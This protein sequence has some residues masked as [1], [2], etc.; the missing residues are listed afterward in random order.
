MS[1]ARRQIV[2]GG[3]LRALGPGFLL[4]SLMHL[5]ALLVALPFIGDCGQGDALDP[6]AA[7]E[8]PGD[9]Q[10]DEEP[11]GVLVEDTPEARSSPEISDLQAPE[12]PPTAVDDPEPTLTLKTPEETPPEPEPRRMLKEENNLIVDQPLVKE[13]SEPPPDTRVLGPQDR[14]VLEE[15]QPKQRALE[16]TPQA[17]EDPEEKLIEQAEED[18]DE[19]P[20]ETQAG[21]QDPKGNPTQAEKPAEPASKIKTEAKAESAQDPSEARERQKAGDPGQPAEASL[22]EEGVNLD[23][24]ARDAA[25]A[26]GAP[27]DQRQDQ[28]PDDGQEPGQAGDSARFDVAAALRVDPGAYRQMFG[29][30]D[31]EDLQRI[32]AAERRFLGN[33]EKRVKATRAALENFVPHVRYGN[34]IAINTRHSEY[35]VYIAAVHRK[36]HRLWG[37][38]YL[39]HLDLHYPMG[40]P[41]SDP[42]LI[43]T[44]EY[45]IDARTGEL[46]ECTIVESS[47][48][49]EFDAEAIRV[50]FIT[51]PYGPAPKAITSPDGNVYL[52]W[53]YHR[54][55]RQCGTF[56]VSVYVLDDDGRVDRFRVEE[57]LDDLDHRHPKGARHGGDRPKAI[58]PAIISTPVRRPS[59]KPPNNAKALPRSPGP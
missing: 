19:A 37:I 41:L 30:R 42:N 35:A 20:E 55:T 8:Q 24:T 25:A 47:G 6:V 51:S 39:R 16:P 49:T 50:G 3:R 5:C 22:D 58:D 45:V 54:D 52:H 27:D 29:D 36:I 17:P 48:Q 28:Q 7:V 40:H 31:A 1:K 13:E 53:R 43:A 12:E 21:A 33:W 11:L 46:K 57:E 23:E 14:R 59:P 26:A 44:V 18:P 2:E 10:P 34:Q 4:S 9:L 15:T 56:G 38:A 32:S